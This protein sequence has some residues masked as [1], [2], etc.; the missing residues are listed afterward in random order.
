M[1]DNPGVD[2]APGVLYVGRRVPTRN[3]ALDV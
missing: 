1:W 2:N 3:S